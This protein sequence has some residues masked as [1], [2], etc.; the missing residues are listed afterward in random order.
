[1]TKKMIQMFAQA[2][3]RRLRDA[4]TA[5]KK[6]ITDLDKNVRMLER[7]SDLFPRRPSGSASCATRP[8]GRS[9]RRA[10]R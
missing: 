7:R 2:Q 6:A 9:V 3:D 8:S 4:H 5:A 10:T 1:M